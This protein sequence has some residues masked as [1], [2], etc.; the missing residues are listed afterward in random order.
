LQ[1]KK[2]AENKFLA[3][4]ID[5]EELDERID[6]LDDDVADLDGGEHGLKEVGNQYTFDAEALEAIK[7]ADSNAKLAQFQAVKKEIEQ[8]NTRKKLSLASKVVVDPAYLEESI[9]KMKKKGNAEKVAEFEAELKRINE[10][11][12]EAQ[13]FAEINDIEEFEPI[14]DLTEED[15]ANLSQGFNNE[16]DQGRDK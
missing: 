9:E 11:V 6:D 1:K 12:K 15:V 10:E 3:G 2:R 14:E 4:K 16:S 13:E 7:V 8:R 5:A